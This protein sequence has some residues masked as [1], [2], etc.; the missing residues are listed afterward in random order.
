M[1]PA[2]SF[3]ASPF[4]ICTLAIMAGKRTFVPPVARPLPAGQLTSHGKNP[5]RPHV[6]PGDTCDL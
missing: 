6:P 1:N 5:K 4:F 3:F 2:F